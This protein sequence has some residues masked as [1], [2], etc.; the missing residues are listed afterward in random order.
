M[1]KIK[2]Y[3][4]AILAIIQEQR[5]VVLQ[6]P[7]CYVITDMKKHHYQILLEGWGVKEKH[8]LKVFMHFHIK[9]DGKIYILENHSSTDVG[10]ALVENGVSKSD[11]VLAFL[12]QYAR[13]ESGYAEA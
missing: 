11:I 2:N 12:P 3:E 1:E 4:K 5:P 7:D 8:D 10:E 13:A 6:D 9:P